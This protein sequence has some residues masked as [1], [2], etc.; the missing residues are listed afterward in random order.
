L[1][2]AAN[3]EAWVVNHLSDS[4]SIVR[5]SPAVPARVKR[6]LF[7]G[8]EPRDIQFAGPGGNRAFITAAN[9]NLPRI[10]SSSERNADIWVFD[11]ENLGD[12]RPGGTPLA[13]VNLYADVP[14]ALA[15]SP[16]GTTV[17]AAVFNSGNQTS[18]V[19]PRS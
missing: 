15:V 11:A 4:V 16:D 7:V 8:D 3:N 9:R 6:T 10:P 19:G 12:G 5:L 13:V 1:L 14:R 2:P 18:V 17:Y